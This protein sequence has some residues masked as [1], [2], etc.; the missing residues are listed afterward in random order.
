MI[1]GLSLA[2]SLGCS[3][4]IAGFDSLKKIEACTREEMWWN[5]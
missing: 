2:N 5:E 3:V 1:E 4:L